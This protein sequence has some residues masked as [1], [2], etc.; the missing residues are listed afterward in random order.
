MTL[1]RQTISNVISSIRPNSFPTRR[2]TNRRLPPHSRTVSTDHGHGHPQVASLAR[3]LHAPSG[4]HHG[5]SANPDENSTIAN[6]YDPSR[7]SSKSARIASDEELSSIVRRFP[8]GID[9]AFGYGS[10][11]LRQGDSDETSTAKR[12]SMIDVIL[13]VDDPRKWH[14]ENLGRHPDHYSSFSRLGGADFV[15]WMQTDFGAK[16]LFHPFVD[17]RRDSAI[18][19]TNN[20][21]NNNNNLNNNNNNNNRQIKYGMVST[22]DLLRDL[23]HWDHLYLAG[24]MHKPTVSILPPSDEIVEAQN[25]NL[26]SA[27]SASL[28]LLSERQIPSSQQRSRPRP[29]TEEDENQRVVAAI[30]TPRLYDTIASLSYTGDFRMDTGA[31]D[32]NKVMKLVHTPGM[33]ELWE[34][35]YR[36]TL[37]GLEKVGLLSVVETTNGYN[38]DDADDDADADHDNA[39]AGASIPKKALELDLC[40]HSTRRELMKH[41]PKK[42]QQYSSDIVGSPET[43]AAIIEG[44][45]QSNRA[46]VDRRRLTRGGEILRRALANIVAPAARSQSIKGFFSAGVVKSWRYAMAK[47]AKGRLKK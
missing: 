44:S 5:K 28:L 1:L 34:S 39:D 4:S 47:L 16:I 37:E 12:E 38:F 11:V 6:V 10:M 42:L 19:G 21:N 13:S 31:E 3:R 15:A 18:D 24:R 26:K 25:L 33:L 46:I 23:T 30:A 20:H 41:L 27:V 14:R 2:P 43:A 17:L 29:P 35:T 22:N 36:E 45:G 7:R 9:Y 8:G 32:P 40:D